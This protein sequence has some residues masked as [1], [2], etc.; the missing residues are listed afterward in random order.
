MTTLGF[1][2]EEAPSFWRS[3]AADG[4][5]ILVEKSIADISRKTL[6]DAVA[7]GMV[8]SVQCCDWK[9]KMTIDK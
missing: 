2:E 3:V 5:E 8:G 7:A 4:R 6:R 1:K 9:I